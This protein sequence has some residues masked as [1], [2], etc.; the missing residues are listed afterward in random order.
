LKKEEEILNR[1][2]THNTFIRYFET[3]RNINLKIDNF[4][5]SDIKKL[6]RNEN[7]YNFQNSGKV[8]T[9]W[10]L[11][12]DLKNKKYELYSDDNKKVVLKIDL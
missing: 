9:I 1:K 4:K 8:F 12:L 3:L 5:F 11:A 2:P 6:L 7:C 10:T